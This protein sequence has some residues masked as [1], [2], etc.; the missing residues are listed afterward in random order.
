MY[1]LFEVTNS[2]VPLHTHLIIFRLTYVSFLTVRCALRKN[3]FL[4]N[5]ELQVQ[6][7]ERSLILFQLQQVSY[8]KTINMGQK[9]FILLL[10]GFSILLTWC[11]LFSFQTYEHEY[12]S[13]PTVLCLKLKKIANLLI[14]NHILHGLVYISVIIVSSFPNLK[15]K[16]KITWELFGRASSSWN[17]VKC[18]LDATS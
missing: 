3:R 9:C 1:C 12:S 18:Q 17:K 13:L 14:Q 5:I 11:V 8:M 7:N 10:N 6:M 16:K 2:R 4:K 15:L